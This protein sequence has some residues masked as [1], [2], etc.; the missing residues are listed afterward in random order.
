MSIS[1]FPPIPHFCFGPKNWPLTSARRRLKLTFVLEALQLEAI[2][3]KRLIQ[4][5][6]CK[7]SEK[8]R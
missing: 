2:S 6:N 3:N 7:S 1:C 4:E 8:F 5:I